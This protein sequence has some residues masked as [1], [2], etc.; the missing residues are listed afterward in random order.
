MNL[1]RK[2]DHCTIEPGVPRIA[3]R[4][5]LINNWVERN[6]QGTMLVP[7][8]KSLIYSVYQLVGIVQLVQVNG[9]LSMLA[10]FWF[11]NFLAPTL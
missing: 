6:K 8:R 9:C 5:V 3:F 1:E 10:V 4:V 2:R 7:V 11:H